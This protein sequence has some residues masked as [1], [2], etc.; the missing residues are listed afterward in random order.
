[1]N[2]PTDYIFTDADGNAKSLVDLFEGRRQLILYHFMLD[3]NSKDLCSGCS[4]TADNLPSNMSHLQ[5][6]DTTF[7]MAAPASIDKLNA[8]KKR[9]DWTFP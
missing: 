6:R 8:A 4:F 9:M 2:N 5:S 3:D 1:V 7:A